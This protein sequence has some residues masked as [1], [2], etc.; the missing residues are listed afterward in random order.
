M[1]SVTK[2]KKALSLM[3]GYVI[4]IT[5]AVAMS[6]IIYQWMKS[7]VPK[8]KLQCPEDVSLFIKNYSCDSDWLNMTLKNN[9]NFGVSGYF[10]HL[11]NKSDVEL[12]T[13]DLSQ[14][15]KG[16]GVIVGNS[17]LFSYNTNNS[18]EPN[19]ESTQEFD[20]TGI[21]PIY[22]IEITP[23]R[24]QKENNKLRFVSCSTSISKENLNC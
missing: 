24:Y 19:K 10:V 13:V 7:Y 20:I 8:E 4:L 9:G 12:A 15:L 3:I 22:S 17:V 2:N 11:S 1:S 16:G 18:F 21:T 14:R 23:V 5:I 6:I